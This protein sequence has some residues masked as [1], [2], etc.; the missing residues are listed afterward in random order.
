MQSED[1]VA[2]IVFWENLTSVMT[3]NYVPN[4]NFKR[5]MPDSAQANWNMVRVIYENVAQVYTWLHV[6]VH[7]FFIGMRACIK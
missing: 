7:V 6:S 4:V 5:F 1:G 3:K 2:Q